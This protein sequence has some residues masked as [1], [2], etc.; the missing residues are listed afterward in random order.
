KM[1]NSPTVIEHHTGSIDWEGK[2]PNL[3][4]SFADAVVGYDYV[5]TMKLNLKEGR[6]FS[7][8]YGTDSA[9]YLLNET[10][11]ARMNYDHALGKTV[12]WGNRPGKIIGI[13]KD[14][15]FNSM[16]QAIDPLIVRLDDQWGWGTIL[17]RLKA[18]QTKDAIS[19]LQSVCKKLNPKFPF[20]YQFS[21]EEYSK[22][23]RSE[24][25]VSKLSDYFA[26]LAIF[27]SCLGLFGL[28][29]FSANQRIKEIG[30][31]KVLGASVTDIV[32]MLTINFLKPVA[33]SILIA[34]PVS[35]YLMRHW[36]NNFAYK[37]DMEWWMFAAA[38]I[39]ALIIAL[40]TNSF[41]SVRAAVSNPAKSLRSE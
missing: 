9:S 39:L 27:I 33:I 19:T 35:L 40:L 29:T 25:L 18:N 11:A 7:A 3:T 34:I 2:D 28:A 38:G 20:T 37:I 30:V 22:L 32:T 12:R 8:D 23:Y 6:D 14:F 5:K 31:R 36:L 21:D 17:V 26:F 16:H 4:V 1:R 10:A 24:Q 41:Q 13:L 15:H